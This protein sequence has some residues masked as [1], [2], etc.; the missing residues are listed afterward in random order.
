MNRSVTEMPEAPPAPNTY[1]TTLLAAGSN[2]RGQL[3]TGSI[4]DAHTLTPCVFKGHGPH[5]TPANWRHQ[6]LLLHSMTDFNVLSSMML[7]TGLPVY[8]RRPPSSY[9][10]RYTSFAFHP[11]EMMYAVGEPDGTVKLMGSKLS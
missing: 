6:R 1:P 5:F 10:P 7:P 11:L 2:A 9:I 8:S 4:D 3:G